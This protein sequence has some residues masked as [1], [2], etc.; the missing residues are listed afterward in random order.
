M[1]KPINLEQEIASALDEPLIEAFRSKDWNCDRSVFAY[2]RRGF[3]YSFE[4][5]YEDLCNS[6]R[7]RIV[8]E[9]K[10]I[11]YEHRSSSGS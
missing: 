9:N 1:N 10:R 3:N 4:K 8:D 11:F 2:P 5:Y 6:L 7:R